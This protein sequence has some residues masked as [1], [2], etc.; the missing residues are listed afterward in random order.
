M[1]TSEK[2]GRAE[3]SAS[4]MADIAFL[5]LTFFMVT[6]II[7]NEKGLPLLLP[8][9]QTDPVTQPILDRNLFKIQINSN[10]QLLIEGV[11]RKNLDDVRN[12]IKSFVLNDGVDPELSISPVK[13]IVSLKADRGTSHGA[14]V[15]VLDE[16]QGA[17]YEIYAE[18][19][20]LSAE[21]YR[22]LD[23]NNRSEK[24]TYDKAR[25]GI[26]MNI[27]IAEPTKAGVD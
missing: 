23:L 19:V 25:T 18:R 2:I 22:M 13:A 4:S 21:K 14:F 10:D 17:Y 27:S 1:R 26:P 5:L 20:G 6:T 7:S 24:S 15:S 8:P 16:I 11:P 3:I 9:I 12:E